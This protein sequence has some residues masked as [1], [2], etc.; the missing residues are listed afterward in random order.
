MQRIDFCETLE[1]EAK[2][3]APILQVQGTVIQKNN[4]SAQTEKQIDSKIAFGDQKIDRGWNIG[5]KVA[6]KMIKDDPP[7]SNPSYGGEGIYFGPAETSGG[8]IG[9]DG[10]IVRHAL[11]QP[12]GWTIQAW[13][14]TLVE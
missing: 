12:F 11:D 2:N 3:L 7:S 1:I 9:L 4:K 8:K 5:P 6:V 10:G 13:L 14:R